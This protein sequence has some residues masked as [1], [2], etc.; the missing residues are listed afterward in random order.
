M[1]RQLSDDDVA[2][3]AYRHT[4]T[5]EDGA[6]EEGEQEDLW[7]LP[8]RPRDIAGPI[9]GDCRLGKWDALRGR[10]PA[11]ARTA[12]VFVTTS[13]RR[14]FFAP[15]QQPSGRRLI[16]QRVCHVYEVDMGVHLT[17]VE[18]KLPCAGDQC[19]FDGVVELRWRVSD[20]E[21]AVKS[22]VSNVANELMP[23]ITKR[24]REVT[25]KFD[26]EQVHD[27]ET[28][29]ADALTGERLGVDFGL[30]VQVFLNFSM[31]EPTLAHA[32][33]VR[34]VD[35][36]R[37]IIAEGDYHQFALQLSLREDSIAEVIQTLAEERHSSKQVV[38]DFLTRTLESDAIERWE[39]EDD[40]RVLLQSMREWSNNELAAVKETRST[41]L[42]AGRRPIQG[43][44]KR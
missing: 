22:G 42:G 8:E 5:G 14:L 33:L 26:I 44:E 27:A 3:Q 10:M 2:S 18:V 43:G 28:A 13:G 24:L 21:A 7:P 23:E 30:D 15:D 32:A 38:V 1:T 6:A 37:H 20:A 4:A 36:L 31:D 40:L 35:R 11:D 41:S 25:R 16:A 39:I 19:F 17:R 12:R 9:L 29:A 34:K